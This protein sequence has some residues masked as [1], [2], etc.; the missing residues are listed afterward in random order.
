MKR[1]IQ[2]G[3]VVTEQG[4]QAL[5]L[6]IES[7]RIIGFHA[8]GTFAPRDHE[9][10][11]ARGLIVMPGAIDVHTHFTGPHDSPEEELREGTLGAAI[12]GITTIIEM[13]HSDPPAT[14]PAAF[15]RKRE[16]LEATSTLDFGLW[17]G[18]TNDNADSLAE[19]DSLGAS[20]F[21]AFLTSGNPS[22][23]APDQRGLPQMKDSALL[24][25]MKRIH[26]FDGVVGVHAENH[27]LLLE[28]RLGEQ[29]AGRRD[30]RAHAASAP[31]IAEI[32]AVSRLMLFAAETG[33]RCHVVHV[34][35]PRAV[36]L[37]RQASASGV[38]AT[39]ETCPHY[40]ILDEEDLVRIGPD[41]RCG[42]PLRPRP[43]VDALWRH[44]LAGRIDMLSSDHCPYLPAQKRVGDDSIWEAGM[45]LTGVQTLGPMFFSE[46]VA[47]RGLGLETFARMTATAPAH[48]MGLYPRK[49]AIR[50]GADADLALYDPEAQW[51]VRG[52]GFHGL[53]PW[54]AFEGMTCRSR[55]VRTLLR[56]QDVQV[57]GERRLVPGQGQFVTR[58]YAEEEV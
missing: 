20:A 24:K 27:E 46:A 32:E 17:A 8:H 4:A 52:E 3:T 45:G 36:E 11:D 30:A 7:G 16:L 10:I 18:L 28:A 38:R 42:P 9:V 5:D 58:R 35:S 1:L 43:T 50:I 31:E 37:I 15:R 44:A 25:A 47:E 23:E 29:A 13:P 6:V 22:G 26:G 56:G 21:K 40:L 57:D 19:L 2:G 48:L 49:G 55:V 33:V 51:T 12:G 53:A 14:T 34:S 41:A 39:L 54:S